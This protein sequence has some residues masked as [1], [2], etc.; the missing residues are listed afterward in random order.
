MGK[1]STLQDDFTAGEI[2]PRLAARESAEVFSRGASVM[3][4]QMPVAQGAAVRRRGTQYFEEV[5]KQDLSPASNGRIISMQD[6]DTSTFLATM[7]DGE[8]VLYRDVIYNEL[9]TKAIEN[10]EFTNGL[11]GWNID[12]PITAE[13][14]QLYD[15][16]LRL[17]ANG[18]SSS[19]GGPQPE[20]LIEQVFN[21]SLTPLGV[22]I[23]D[24][25]TFWEQF[26]GSQPRIMDTSSATISIASDD[27]LET[28][29]ECQFGYRLNG[30]IDLSHRAEVDFGGYAGVCKISIQIFVQSASQFPS[31][32]N[33]YGYQYFD[34]IDLYSIN[35]APTKVDA[36]PNWN[37]L[38]DL[39][40]WSVSVLSGTISTEHSKFLGGS[41]TCNTVS[42][43]SDTS[44]YTGEVL[45]E[46]NINVGAATFDVKK[47]FI[48]LMSDFFPNGRNGKAAVKFLIQDT[49]WGTTPSVVWYEHDVA[50]NNNKYY[51]PP[52]NSSLW[53]A[54]IYNQSGEIDFEGWSGDIYCIAYIDSRLSAFQAGSAGISGIIRLNAFR[55]WEETPAAPGG[56]PSYPVVTIPY[57]DD[58]LKV[59]QHVE[60]PFTQ[61]VVFV[62]PDHEPHRLWYDGIGLTWN[63]DPI[64]FFWNWDSAGTSAWIN[65]N[66]PRT[67]GAYQGRLILGGTLDFPQTVWCTVP[68]EWSRIGP[69]DSSGT[70]QALDGIS[71][72]LTDIGVIQWIEGQK[73]LLIGTSNGEHA[74]SA[75]QGLLQPGDID[76][77]RQS[78]YGSSH[79]QAENIGDQVLYASGNGR[80]IRAAEFSRDYNG[81]MSPDLTLISEHITK[82]GVCRMSLTR[83][84]LTE[85]VWMVLN[86][87]QTVGMSYERSNNLLGWHQHYFGDGTVD[88]TRHRVNGQDTLAL[89]VKRKGRLFIEIM[90]D[91]S[92][93]LDSYDTIVSSPPINTFEGL[94]RFEGEAVW[95]LADDI[96]VGLYVVA[97]GKIVLPVAAEHIHA[98]YSYQSEFLTLPITGRRAGMAAKK[99]QHR[100]GVRL[101][102]SGQPLIN[103]KRITPDRYGNEDGVAGMLDFT[104]QVSQFSLGWE[105][106]N[107][108]SIIE[109]EPRPMNVI[110]LYSDAR[111]ENT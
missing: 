68:G 54:E 33:D 59:I 40:S 98:G 22:L 12:S 46:Q 64:A 90:E 100:I 47:F 89:L 28:F 63:F 91:N 104:G 21:E 52:D 27:G 109:N 71:F 61:D 73:Q 45:C 57:T 32:L 17:F 75:D 95:V 8:M 99:T 53:P 108:I 55:L 4:N 2:S 51:Y 38:D 111:A 76:A 56:A 24:W 49:P 42:S 50:W 23:F 34:K 5:L 3:R 85:T 78:Q 58:E 83:D 79:V 26:F 30:A 60:D 87:G 107:Q 43:T 39:S 6:N 62:H 69:F 77:R 10:G 29:Y 7:S 110:G 20:I 9:V 103:G 82:A 101:V 44:A 13:W 86:N 36:V 102:N 11:D 19:Q 80:K 84:I 92:E 94:D 65:G 16:S 25:S 35:D 37:F 48:E 31:Q 72:T 93:L 81:W 88:L 41:L 105:T 106:V 97:G 18:Y 67:C 66:Y 74:I 1:W 15:G 70:P 96:P 14:T